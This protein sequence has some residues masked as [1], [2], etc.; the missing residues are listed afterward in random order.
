M[1]ER[2]RFGFDNE[3]L[4]ALVYTPQKPIGATLLLGHGAS[5]GQKGPFVVEYAGA[6]AERGVLVVTYD[7]PFAE[8]GRPTPDRYDVL[9]AAFRAATVAAHR[10]RPRNRLFVGGKSLGGRVATQVVA[11]G[12][13]EVESVAG[14]VVLGY[15]LHPVGRPYESHARHLIGLGVPVLYVQ[16]ER[17]VLGT[18]SELRRAL[19]PVPQGTE[20]YAVPGGD[21]SLLVPRAGPVSARDARAEVEDE[22]ARWITE[23]MVASRRV[24]SRPRPIASRLRTQLRHLRRSSSW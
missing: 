22:I 1:T 16:G 13:D 18:P 11:E 4:T 19:G 8:H 7:F 20:I 10:C 2:F 14:V 12:G 21:H 3:R 15:P 23:R 6:L 9:E 24:A 17:D 5:T